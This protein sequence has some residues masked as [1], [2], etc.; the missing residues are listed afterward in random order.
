M[1]DI[2]TFIKATEPA[3]VN[4]ALVPPTNAPLNKFAL[5]KISITNKFKIAEL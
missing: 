2:N 1:L 5:A 4:P 3:R